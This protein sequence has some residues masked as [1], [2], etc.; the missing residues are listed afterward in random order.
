M[1]QKEIIFFEL[2]EGG[3]FL[4][5]EVIRLAHPHA[6]DDWDHRWVKSNVSLKAGGFSGQFACDLMISDFQIFKEQLSA[7]YEKM[8]GIAI[9]STVEE[10]IDIKIKGDGLGHFEAQC[11]VMDSPGTGNSLDFELEFDQT[12][13]PQIVNQLEKVIQTFPVSASQK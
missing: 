12:F 13:I 5:I 8:D 11:K 10:Q 9:F 2:K 1:T 7:L 6:K 4:R 3:D